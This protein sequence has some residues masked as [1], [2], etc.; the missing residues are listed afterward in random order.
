MLSD[1]D[2]M[3]SD[4]CLRRR[5]DDNHIGS[6]PG[7]TEPLIDASIDIYLR[8][9]GLARLDVIG[10]TWSSD[11][12]NGKTSSCLNDFL[13]VKVHICFTSSSLDDAYRAETIGT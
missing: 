10:L 12:V 5:L 7:H 13:F 6:L 3:S 4:L 8:C 11:D 2:W 1:D 9:Q